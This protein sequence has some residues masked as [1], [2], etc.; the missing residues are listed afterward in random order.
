MDIIP[1]GHCDL[2]HIID[3]R[4]KENYPSGVNLFD[5]CIPN[6]VYFTEFVPEHFKIMPSAL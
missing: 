1:A 2:Q 4:T 5:R 3:D 6:E